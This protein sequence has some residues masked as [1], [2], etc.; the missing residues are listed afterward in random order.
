M[1]WSAWNK[2]L[3]SEA[4]SFQIDDWNQHKLNRI[5]YCVCFQNKYSISKVLILTVNVA[6]FTRAI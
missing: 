2:F 5:D 3:S 4:D 1:E 6:L